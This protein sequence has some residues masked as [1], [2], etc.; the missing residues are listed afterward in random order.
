VAVLD[1]LLDGVLEELLDDLDE[2]VELVAAFSL[3]LPVCDELV[4]LVEDE[5]PVEVPLEVPAVELWVAVPMATEAPTAPA[6]PSAARTAWARRLRRRRGF[7]P[8][9]VRGGLVRTL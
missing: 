7:M 8:P 5:V 3:G 4:P 2:P 6:T 1:V 9:S